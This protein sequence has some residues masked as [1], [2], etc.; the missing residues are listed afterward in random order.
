MAQMPQALCASFV[1]R[2]RNLHN[3][4]ENGLPA[5]GRVGDVHSGLRKD[6]E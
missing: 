4:A 5:E 3:H 2:F 6:N 1:Y